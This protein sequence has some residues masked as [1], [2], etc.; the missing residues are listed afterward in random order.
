MNRALIQQQLA[1]A[2]SEWKQGLDLNDLPLERMSPPIL[3]QVTDRYCDADIR[4]IVFGQETHGWT[5][6]RNL[7][8]DYPL[9]PQNWDYPNQ[10][11]L[12]DFLSQ[13]TS[14]EALCWEYEQFAFA[15]HQPVSW[16][17]PF[18]Q[19]FRAIE[20]WD[21]A[22]VMWSNVFRVDYEGGSI[23]NA[24]EAHRKSLLEQQA[25]VLRRE[26]EI[27]KPHACIFLTGPHYDSIL[28]YI[29]PEIQHEVV[30]PVGDAWQLAKL[31]HPSL[32]KQ[33]YRTYHPAYLR[34]STKWGY[35]DYVR[36]QIRN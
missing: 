33:A 4:I 19:A 21:N 8:N 12:R 13:E 5:W 36:A 15:K 23:L 1:S 24:N 25:D 17:S 10:I 29:F 28:E 16:R 22:G 3:L 27:L 35:L 30:A 20:S 11:N 18:W 32:P 26:I 14:I 34:R 7:T 9:Y 31:M 2:Y 6:D